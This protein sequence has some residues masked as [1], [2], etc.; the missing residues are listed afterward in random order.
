[1]LSDKVIVV[2]GGSGLLGQKIIQKLKFNGAI[3]LNVDIINK[4]ENSFFYECDICKEKSVDKV[5]ANILKKYKKIDGWINNA[6]PR[7]TDWHKEIEEISFESWRTNVDMHLNGYFLCSQRILKIMKK[8]T[9]GTLINLASIYGELAPDFSLYTNIEGMT[10]PAAYSAIKGGIINLTRY[11]A[12][13]YGPY[14]VRVNS[15]SPGGIENNQ[16]EV[17][18]K[19]YKN[20]VPLNRMGTTD[21]VANSVLYLLSPLS[22]YVN[23]HNL[24][25]D[26][27][28]SII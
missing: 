9:E 23:G 12:A 18:I 22:K 2:T 14:N 1:M 13:Y 21:D 6:Y 26:G 10:M 3:A 28:Y 19:R 4:G 5:I 27:G 15:I 7:T 16:N 20:R 8:Q 25:V 17:F 11:L 24:V